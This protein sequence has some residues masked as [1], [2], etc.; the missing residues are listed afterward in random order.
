VSAVAAPAASPFKGLAAFSDTELDALFFFGRERERAVLVANLLASRLTVLY[1]ESGVGKSSLLAAAV[2]RDLR[3]TAPDAVVSLLDTWSEPVEDALAAVAGADEAYLILDQFEEY[4]LY[5]G[6]A[7]EPGSLLDDLPDLL[8]DTRV[9]VLIAM[10]EDSLARLDTLKNRIPTIFANQVRLEH[11]DRDSARRAILGPIDRWNEVAPAE[12][13]GIESALVEAVLDECAVEGRAGAKDR[14]EA[15]YLQLVLERIW[16]QERRAGSPAL[17]LETMRAL[18]GAETIVREHLHGALARLDVEEEDVAASMFEH[19]VTPSGTK[20]AHRA[21]DL[22]QYADVPEE[23]L[24]RVLTKL[25]HDRIVHS[26][27]GSDRYEIFHDVLA[28]PIRGWRLQRRL[29]RERAIAQRRQRRLLVVVALSLCALAGVG[30]LAVWALTERGTARSQAR[31]ARARELEA[32]ALQQL[33]TD[34]NRAVRSALQATRLEQGAAAGTVLRQALVADRLRLVKH[35]VGPVRAVATSP[36]GDLV[37]A[38]GPGGRVFLLDARN[39]RLVR[40]IVAP[41]FVAALSFAAGGRTLL[42]ASPV[43]IAE[44]WD[45]QTGKRVPVRGRVVAARTPDGA[46]RLVR[47]RGQL[48]RIIPHVRRL[49]TAADGSAVAAAVAR[50]DGRVRALLFDETGRLVRVLPRRGVTDVAFSPDGALVATATADGF[51]ILWNAHT[52]VFV[53]TLLGAKSGIDVLAFSP[54]GSLLA[55]GGDDLRIWDVANGTRLFLLFGHTNPISSLAWSPDGRV[56]ASGSSD[57]TVLLWRMQGLPGPGSLAATLA[58]SGGAI[59]ALAFSRDGRQLVTAGDDRAVRFWDA[60]PDEQLD[61]LGRAAGPALAARWAG[62][63]IVGLWE[64]VVQTYDLH[65]RRLTHV[66]R[67]LGKSRFTALGVSSDGSVIAAGTDDGRTVVWNGRTGEQLATTD[68]GAAIGA[69]AV[70][71]DGGLIASGDRRGVV[72]VLTPSALRWRG[73]QVGAVVDVSFSS[74][75]DEIVTSGPRGVVVWSAANGRRLHELVSP[76]GVATASFSPDGRLI[77]AAGLDDTARLWFARSGNPYRVLRGHTKP[78]TDAEFSADGRLL[79]T[80]GKDD[81][82][83]VWGVE[84]GRGHL[85]QRRAFGP[86]A[87]AALDATGRWVAAAAP[88]S[89]II[90][91][92]SDGR[93]LF[94]VRGHKALLTGVS[95]AP[96]SETVL[97]SSQDGTI[98]T[99]ACNVCVG[100]S[101]LVHLAEAQLART[102]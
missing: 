8:Y 17:R 22:A 41:R 21:P 89:V 61:V 79:V 90:W 66:L 70:S 88:I 33:A 39:R 15:P 101:T 59:R 55:T 91:S 68:G 1:G 40:T 24:R 16:E 45:V 80:S 44:V 71:R 76:G 74:S 50:P 49:S 51:A 65:T 86:V 81:D 58:G 98:R 35:I 20:I 14:V 27:D 7:A 94:Y 11:L 75:G 37:A 77:A 64:R 87:A 25:S 72:R 62:A 56:L 5:Q 69:V 73:R 6:E 93:Q 13:V 54:D 43:G 85:L 97:S 3:A 4:F 63:S 32:T 57:R 92:S 31:H 28:E 84:R 19:L 34:P 82:V 38:A 12:R 29:D 48:A 83:R 47:V 30:A 26:V 53:R 78:L 96:N 67:A 42:T 95:F 10:R 46:L 9:N 102:R 60:R 2:V 23:T 52:G 36:R 99:Y 100:L 18:G